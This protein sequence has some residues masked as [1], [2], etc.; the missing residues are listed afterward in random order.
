MSGSADRAVPVRRGEVPRD[1]GLR[2]VLY[3][4]CEKCR[5]T[6]GH[7]SAYSSARR[8]TWS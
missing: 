2:D 7:V 8:E 6:H 4:H 5:R 3:C 1:G